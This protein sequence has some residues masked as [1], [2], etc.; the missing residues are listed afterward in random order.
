[1][2]VNVDKLIIENI[3][4]DCLAGSEPGR[5]TITFHLNSGSTVTNLIKNVTFKDQFII[6]EQITT[7]EDEAVVGSRQPLAYIFYDS[8]EYVSF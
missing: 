1:M 6:S 7:E 8:I 2:K 3:L 5:R 4:E